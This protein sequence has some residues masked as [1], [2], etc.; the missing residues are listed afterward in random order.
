[1]RL[2]VCCLGLAVDSTWRAK[3]DEEDDG[4]DDVV[5]HE[6]LMG[7]QKRLRLLGGFCPSQ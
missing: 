1:M 4:D 5:T 3:K 7:E 6:Y 2:C